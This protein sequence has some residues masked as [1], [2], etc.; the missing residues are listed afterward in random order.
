MRGE[1]ELLVQLERRP[2]VTAREHPQ[3]NL[4]APLLMQ[5][6]ARGL[7]LLEPVRVAARRGSMRFDRRLDR[8]QLPGGNRGPQRCLGRL[9][10]SLRVAA[11]AG[12]SALMCDRGAGGKE[13]LVHRSDEVDC[14]GARRAAEGG[15]GQLQEHL[16]VLNARLEQQTQ[17]ACDRDTA[18]QTIRARLP[19]PPTAEGQ[20]VAQHLP[21]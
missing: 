12:R 2:T 16:L 7:G 6:L 19:G 1:Y 8:W 5:P 20:V 10:C 21:H 15:L 11:A 13:D 14:L 9:A 18:V 4:Y 3:H 17:Q